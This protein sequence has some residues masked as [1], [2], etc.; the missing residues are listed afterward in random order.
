MLQELVKRLTERVTLL[1]AGAQEQRR[2]GYT[3]LAIFDSLKYMT[4]GTTPTTAIHE[5]ILKR[6]C[7]FSHCMSPN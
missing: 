4:D 6:G 7:G 2:R 1:E 3:A 5:P